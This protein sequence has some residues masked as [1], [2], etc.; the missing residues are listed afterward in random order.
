MIPI[1][2]WCDTADAVN[3]IIHEM[4]RP[5]EQRL[6]ELGCHWV[7]RIMPV[8]GKVI[9]IEQEYFIFGKIFYLLKVEL[10]GNFEN[11]YGYTLWKGKPPSE[12]IYIFPLPAP[13]DR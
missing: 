4:E 10:D 11:K 6:L 1:T 12:A 5:N 8:A 9:K 2:Q 3:T 7:P 13:K